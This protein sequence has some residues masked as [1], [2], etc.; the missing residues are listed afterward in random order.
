MSIDAC[1]R[2]QGDKVSRSHDDDKCL[3]AFLD[4]H[5]VK[6]DGNQG[7][8]DFDAFIDIVPRHFA[9]AF[10]GVRFNQMTVEGTQNHEEVGTCDHPVAPPRLVGKATEQ[11]TVD[12]EAEQ[13]KDS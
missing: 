5:E 7:E 13:Q 1:L 9:R 2:D 12:D 4:K 8:H 10:L 3:T 6:P 11:N